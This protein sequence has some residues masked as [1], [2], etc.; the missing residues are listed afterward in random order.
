MQV[1]P[2]SVLHSSANASPYTQT[3]D[4]VA[5]RILSTAGLNYCM[6]VTGADHTELKHCVEPIRLL[7]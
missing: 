5:E 7:I 3:G 1:S 4:S 6:T 2:Y